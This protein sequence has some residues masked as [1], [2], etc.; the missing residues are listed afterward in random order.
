MT[1][2][3]QQTLSFLAI[4]NHHVVPVLEKYNLDFCCKGKRTLADACKEKGIDLENITH[5]LE[6]VMIPDGIAAMPL[7]TMTA[8]KLIDDILLH[9]HELLKYEMPIIYSHLERVVYK[10]GDRFPY[11]KQVFELFA[12]VQ[13]DMNEHMKKEENDSFPL[14]K[15]LE[16]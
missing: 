16:K 5:E 15:E 2:L 1:D 9:E 10:H 11:M 14:I 3:S 6:S 12:S 8:E 4:T 13:K 7:A